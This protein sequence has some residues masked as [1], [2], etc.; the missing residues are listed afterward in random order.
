VLAQFPSITISIGVAEY[1]S[2]VRDAEELLQFADEALFQI[3]KDGNKTCVA[4]AP[5]G[6]V[7]DFEVNEKGV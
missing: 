3:R 4:K 5:Q 1:P 6:F 2:M 7:A